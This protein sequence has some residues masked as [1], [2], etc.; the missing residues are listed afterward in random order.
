M[1]SSLTLI[2]PE[3]EDADL[4]CA[5]QAAHVAVVIQQVRLL[6][7]STH[8]NEDCRSAR[9]Q[10]TRQYPG[11]DFTCSFSMAGY[12][13]NLHVPAGMSREEADRLTGRH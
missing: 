5:A 9:E 11:L 8:P 3:A 10:L 2:S 1:A 12:Y 4:V 13:T 6:G 7:G